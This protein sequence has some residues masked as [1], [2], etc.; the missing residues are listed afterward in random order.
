MFLTKREEAGKNNETE[1]E[2]EKEVFWF[3]PGADYAVFG[4]RVQ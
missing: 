1:G 3:D 4:C 2:N